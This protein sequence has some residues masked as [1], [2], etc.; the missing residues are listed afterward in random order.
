MTS[1][2]VRA[3]VRAAEIGDD[4]SSSDSFGEYLRARLIT[5]RLVSC[6]NT[7]PQLDDGRPLDLWIVFEEAPGK[8]DAYLIV[9]DERKLSL[10]NGSCL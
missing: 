8:K 7:F 9:F 2:K 6:H 4:S 3:I 5:P 1:D 10:M